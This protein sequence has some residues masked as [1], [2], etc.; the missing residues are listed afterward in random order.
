VRR[1]RLHPEI[2][3]V[4]GE[5]RHDVLKHRTSALGLLR[6]DQTTLETLSAA[7][8]TPEPCSKVVADAYTRLAAAARAE[9]LTLRR[10]KRE[11]VFGAL[12]RDLRRVE[13]IIGQKATKAQKSAILAVDE[14]LRSVHADRLRHLLTLGPEC[15]VDAAEMQRW[16]A[17]VELEWV[18]HKK[19]FVAPA[20]KMSDLVLCFPVERQGLFQIFANLLRNAQA[21]VETLPEPRVVVV[22]GRETDFAGR[23]QLTLQVGDN[24]P[25]TLSLETVE[26]RETGRGLAVLRDTTRHYRGQ[27]VIH[28]AEQ[29]YSKYVGV[30]FAQ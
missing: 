14:R 10:L 27:I 29:P 11:P 5:L 18:R 4:V 6:D 8:L 1:P 26:S 9:G 30:R 20:L 19:R 7:L 25:Q 17:A 2:A 13:R 28:T 24:S 22:L 23:G 16:I 15:Q 3:E 12:F 21:A